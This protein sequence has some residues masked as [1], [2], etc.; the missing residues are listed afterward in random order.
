MSGEAEGKLAG[1]DYG[2]RRIGIAVSDGLGITAQPF[3]QIE[4]DGFKDAVAQL[5]EIVSREGISRIVYGLPMNMDGTISAMGKEVQEF[6]EHVSDSFAEFYGF[7]E[8]KEQR[9]L[10]TPY[11]N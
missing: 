10:R 11:L 6:A 8:K 7:A 9:C 1:I 4:V 2:R 5:A 3:E